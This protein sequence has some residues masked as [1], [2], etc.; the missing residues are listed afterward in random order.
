MDLLNALWCHIVDILSSE[1]FRGFMIMTGVVVAITSVI[2]A[3]NTARKKQTADMMFGTR[4]DD[5]LSEGYKC[6]QRLHNS[7]DS[8]IRALAKDGKKQSD[9]ANQIRYVL[10]HWERIFV[11]LRQGIYD[12]NMLR[13]ANYNTV[14]RTYAQARPYIEAVREEEQKN[15]YYQCLERAAKRWKKKPLVELKR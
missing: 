10:N 12:E 7:D 2:S 3:R 1:A 15:T 9:D 14:L 4:S 8:N 11:G 13:E 6:L 5:M